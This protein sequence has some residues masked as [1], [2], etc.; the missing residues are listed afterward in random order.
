MAFT[1]TYIMTK[2]TPLKAVRAHCV[3]CCGGSTREASLCTA[4]GCPVYPI[5]NGINKDPAT[6][7]NKVKSVLKAIRKRC[8]DCCGFSPKQVGDCDFESCALFVYRFGSNPSRQ[9]VGGA[10]G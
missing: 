6:G 9:G 1:R 8:L 4:N 5:R 7:A 2:L 3:E 10:N